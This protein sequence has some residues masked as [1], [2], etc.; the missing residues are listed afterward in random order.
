MFSSSAT[1][2]KYCKVPSLVPYRPLYS[3][4]PVSHLVRKFARLHSIQAVIQALA[5][6]AYDLIVDNVVF[7]LI[8]KDSDR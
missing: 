3:D 1:V 6:I 7:A 5:Y 4:Y 2:T 8:V